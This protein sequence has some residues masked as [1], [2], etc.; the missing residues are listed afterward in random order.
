MNFEVLLIEMTQNSTGQL[1]FPK[2]SH[3]PYLL[4]YY[5]T[6]TPSSVMLLLLCV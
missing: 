2:C 3:A 6:T 5:T 1:I 4:Y